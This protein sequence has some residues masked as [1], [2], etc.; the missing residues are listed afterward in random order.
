MET[1]V[2]VISMI[3]EEPEAAE[4]LNALL[5]NYRRYII[6]RMGIPYREKG[7]GIIS[8]ALDAPTDT[9]NALTGVL[10]RISGVVAKAAY[11]KT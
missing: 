5:H 11:A 9:I 8:V 4:K 1:R 6:G 2:A 3:V 10:G 7:I